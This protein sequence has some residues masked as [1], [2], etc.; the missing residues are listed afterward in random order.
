MNHD[1]FIPRLV[2]AL[3]AAHATHAYEPGAIIAKAQTLADELCKRKGHPVRQGDLL[4][5]TRFPDAKVELTC[6]RCGHIL[7]YTRD[8]NGAVT[9]SQAVRVT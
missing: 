8:A 2:I 6:Q 4:E 3:A 5:A 1:E 7:Q 9:V